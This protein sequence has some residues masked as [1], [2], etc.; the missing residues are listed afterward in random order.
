[1]SESRIQLSE[2]MGGSR[3]QRLDPSNLIYVVAQSFYIPY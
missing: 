2:A 3:S 1:M